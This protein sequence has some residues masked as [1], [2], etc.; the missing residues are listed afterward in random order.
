MLF[1]VCTKIAGTVLSSLL[2]FASMTCMPFLEISSALAIRFDKFGKVCVQSTDCVIDRRIS[3]GGT[4]RRA[5]G[6]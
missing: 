4:C 5:Y 3:W 6:G 2:T 1:D